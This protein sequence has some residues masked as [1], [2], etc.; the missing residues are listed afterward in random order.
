MTSLSCLP[1][2]KAVWGTEATLQRTLQEVIA[3]SS[4]LFSDISNCSVCVFTGEE[5]RIHMGGVHV[6]TSGQSLAFC[7]T[8]LELPTRARMASQSKDSQSF[9]QCY[10]KPRSPSL[11]F[12]VGSEIE[13]RSLCL[14]VKCFP[15]GAISQVHNLFPLFY[16]HQPR[17]YLTIIF[18]NGLFSSF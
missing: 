9:H 2:N 14:Q 8:G 18:C 13:L 12:L 5:R 4:S 15:N 1:G 6:E 10:Y 3:I 16:W 11:T 7:L 17:I